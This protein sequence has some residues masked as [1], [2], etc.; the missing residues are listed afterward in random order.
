MLKNYLALCFGG[1]IGAMLR[2]FIVQ[3]VQAWSKTT[4]PIETCVVNIIGCFLIGICWNQL[5]FYHAPLWVKLFVITGGI[6]A[7]TT[8]STYITDMLF[9]LE[10]QNAMGVVLYFLLS[11][12]LGL[13]FLLMGF[14]IKTSE[15]EDS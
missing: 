10:R 7:F 5:G 4:F 6:G 3:S 8:F 15:K 1:G 11:N 2:F 14:I 12:G 13:F 9:L